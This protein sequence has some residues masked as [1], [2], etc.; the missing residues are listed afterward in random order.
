MKLRAF[1]AVA[2]S[3]LTIFSYTS[4]TKDAKV[5]NTAKNKEIATQIAI[6]LTNS[7]AATV[8]SG[9]NY[10]GL[11]TTN[12]VVNG[13]K[14]NDLTCGE[15]IEQPFNNT[16]TKGDSIKDVMVGSNKFVINCQNGQP[17]GYTYSGEYTNTG[18]SPYLTTYK[19]TVKEYYTLKSLANNFAKM[20]VDGAQNSTY[21][22]TTRK[23]KEVMVQT[24]TYNLKGLVIDA[25]SRPFDI[26]AG[27]A[28]YV[29]KGN[30]AGRDFSF[31]GTITYLGKH[32]A[33]VTYNGQSIDIEIR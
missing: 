25:S 15:F 6:N 1:A 24:N 4:C 18:F 7:L 13:K 21:N 20:Q 10:S 31:A 11:P 22:F 33:K 3:A 16:Y 19:N 27:V 5:D 2:L 17:N 32:K 23:D 30:N 28:E 12:S 8:A 26:T 14:V 9:N 29:S